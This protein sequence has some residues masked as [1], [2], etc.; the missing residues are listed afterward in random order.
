MFR[1]NRK[2]RR[3]E[4]G[5]TLAF[6]IMLTVVLSMAAVA[7]MTRVF[8]S[9]RHSG[10]TKEHQNTM[11]SAVIGLN[12]A[13]DEISPG[14]DRMRNAV[15]T[16]IVSPDT[17]GEAFPAIA[18]TQAQI[19][20]STG[21]SADIPV[22]E[23]SLAGNIRNWE[24]FADWSKNTTAEW[25]KGWVYVASDSA[26][27][28][29]DVAPGQTG[30]ATISIGND[31]TTG[32][33]WYKQLDPKPP[34]L[35]DGAP[36]VPILN[37]VKTWPNSRGTDFR[38]NEY[39]YGLFCQPVLRKVYMVRQNPMVRVAV[40]VRMSLQDYYGVEIQGGKVVYP[41]RGLDG[42][43]SP[44]WPGHTA[45]SASYDGRNFYD[46]NAITFSVFAVSEGTGVSRGVRI[47]QA[48]NI[49]L[50][51]AEYISG[52]SPRTT[53]AGGSLVANI[54]KNGLENDARLKGVPG[55]SAEYS[56]YL[57]PY[58]AP[59][60][61]TPSG[62]NQLTANAAITG[63]VYPASA[64]LSFR[65]DLPAR[66]K[67]EQAIFLYETIRLPGDNPVVFLI[68]QIPT[69]VSG[70]AKPYW[71][72]RLLFDYKDG[73][74][75]AP[76][77][78]D[79]SHAKSLNTPMMFTRASYSIDPWKETSNGFPSTLHWGNKPA[80]DTITTA[81]G[82]W[83]AFPNPVEHFFGK[84]NL[85]TDFT[86]TRYPYSAQLTGPGTFAIGTQ[87]A[88]DFGIAEGD[89]RGDVVKWDKNPLLNYKG[90]QLD[91]SM[92]WQGPAVPRSTADATVSYAV[93]TWP[94]NAFSSKWLGNGGGV[95]LSFTAAT[96]SVF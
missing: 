15:W 18:H 56:H 88:G 33:Y 83:I 50:G 53:G 87:S 10:F 85:F 47:H 73:Y 28:Y 23:L 1:R 76:R 38:G 86:P 66:P 37:G 77:W 22:R 24:A 11:D 93:T 29:F 84:A 46:T 74:V 49:T 13:I 25:N 48:L 2:D 30:K 64:D 34:T 59:A 9:T 90:G 7:I 8:I 36:D 12:L 44:D 45:A 96:W 6:T 58:F 62:N 82:D 19:K 65:F 40:Y 52:R 39:P 31:V 26:K 17:A 51:G 91:D 89:E 92:P 42:W 20:A 72:R 57:G 55:G 27:Q 75:N 71:R 5:F 63:Q 35:V 94:K 14:L 79:L 60:L 3:Y 95:G 61:D 21:A 4:Q 70:A 16:N 67:H 69:Q 32:A 54:N 68:E 81:H 43:T 41:N 78:D 80:S